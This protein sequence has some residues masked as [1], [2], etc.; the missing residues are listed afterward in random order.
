MEQDAELII[1]V[2]HPLPRMLVYS[3][4]GEGNT[5]FHTVLQMLAGQNQVGGLYFLGFLLPFSPNRGQPTE[6]QPGLSLFKDLMTP[7]HHQPFL[8]KWACGYSSTSLKYLC[9]LGE[10]CCPGT[11]LSLPRSVVFTLNVVFTLSSRNCFLLYQHSPDK[12]YSSRQSVFLCL[13]NQK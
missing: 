12:P 5:H 11:Q 1:R 13:L 8:A 7:F 10:N 3:R 4:H 9:V 6:K 2:R